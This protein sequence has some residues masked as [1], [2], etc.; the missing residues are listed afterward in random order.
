VDPARKNMHWVMLLSAI[1]AGGTIGIRYFSGE[2][3]ID[4][5]FYTIVTLSTVGYGAPPGLS[6]G[7]KVFVIILIIIGISV[8]GLAIGEIS[9]FFV[10][11]KML[12]AMGKRR[13]SRVKDLKDHWILVGLGRVGMEVA[14]HLDSDGIP[15]MALEVADRKVAMA[16]EK[17][18][19]VQQGDVRQEESLENAGIKKA[20]GLILTLSDDSDNVYATLTAKALNPGIRVIARANDPQSAKLLLRAGAERAMNLAD[21]E[22]A[23]I[24]RASVNPAVADFLEM[25]NISRDLGLNFSAVVVNPESSVAGMTLAEAPLRFEY[26]AMVIAIKKEGGSMIYNPPGSEV[27]EGGDEL[28]LFAEM[29][30]MEELRSLLCKSGEC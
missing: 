10:V 18:W 24:A 1:L 13:D 6:P 23:A 3:W 28:I 17:G 30:K 11:E 8:A 29:S 4:S 21:A 2:G 12:S 9:R 14:R 25:V 15:F 16:R 27:L 5:L 22:A 19:L 7:G 20:R 26:N